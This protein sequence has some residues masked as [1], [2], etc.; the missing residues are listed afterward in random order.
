MTASKRTP[1]ARVDRYADHVVIDVDF[2]AGLV[3]A[4]KSKIPYEYRDY[5]RATRT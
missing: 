1:Y 2:S 3:A 5:H 4:I